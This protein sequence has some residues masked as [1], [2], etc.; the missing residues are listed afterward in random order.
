MEVE[1]TP[2][3]ISHQT[4]LLGIVAA[5]LSWGT[6]YFTLCLWNGKQSKEWH[7]RSVT[8]IHAIVILCLC[9]WSA[10]IQGPWPYTRPGM[11]VV[12]KLVQGFLFTCMHIHLH[13][14]DCVADWTRFWCHCVHH[15][16]VGGYWQI[17]HLHQNYT[18]VISFVEGCEGCTIW[19]RHK[20]YK[21]CF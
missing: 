13:V 1:D 21:I 18:I 16:H 7:C 11:C 4:S 10:F 3:D 15:G 6:L 9:A 20:T 12:I 5:L 19:G 17:C 2:L 14:H 8:F